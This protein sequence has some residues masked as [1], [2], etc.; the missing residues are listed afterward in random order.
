MGRMP[1]LNVLDGSVGEGRHRPV[2][3][4]DGRRILPLILTR[5]PIC[6]VLAA[7]LC[8][9]FL[10]STP[11]R[12]PVDGYKMVHAYPHDPHAF[13]QGLVLADG[14]LYEMASRRRD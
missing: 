14:H 1:G 9:V 2:S 12:V 3:F 4:W 8:L 5:M 6:R 7:P 10:A 11:S 13:T